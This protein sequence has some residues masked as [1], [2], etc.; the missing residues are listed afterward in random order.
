M[1]SYYNKYVK[2][3]FATMIPELERNKDYRFNW[4][5]VGYLKQW[6]TQSDIYTKNRFKQL[7]DNG[8]IQFVGG[9]WVQHDE[10]TVE[11]YNAM[12]NLE[13]GIRFLATNFG[14]R[15][16]VGWQLDAFG[17]SAVTPTLLEQYGYDTLFITRVGTQV[18]DNLRENGHLRFIW[19]GHDDQNKGV[20]VTVNQGDLYTVSHQL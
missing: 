12:E 16:H 14:V 20:F 4:A 13:A 18:K 15:P 17:H 9:S 2:E 8:Q 19:K 6:W 1:D 3:I 5:E 11:Y 10:A 7:V